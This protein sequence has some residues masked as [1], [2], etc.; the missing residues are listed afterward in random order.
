MTLHTT[1]SPIFSLSITIQ[2]AIMT[3]EAVFS[4]QR[5]HNYQSYL[6]R[7]SLWE[8]MKT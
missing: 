6:W 1:A 5:T 3:H 7:L 8:C 2:T 4:N